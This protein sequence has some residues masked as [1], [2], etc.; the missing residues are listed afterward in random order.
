M[1]RKYSSN[2]VKN[3]FRYILKRGDYIKIP[4]EI[5][6]Q[7]YLIS[8][9]LLEILKIDITIYERSDSV[10]HKMMF[11][12]ISNASNPNFNEDGRRGNNIE[13]YLFSAAEDIVSL[14]LDNSIDESLLRRLKTNNDREVRGALYEVSIAAAFLRNG[15]KIIWLRGQREPEFTAVLGEIMIDVEAKRR[16]RHNSIHK[17]Y[18]IEKELKAFR[19]NLSKALRKKRT[20]KYL[21]CLDSDL[22]PRSSIDNKDLYDEFSKQFGNY[23]IDNT[24]VL[25]TNSGYEYLPDDNNK[26]NSAY[27]LKDVNSIDN[28]IIK[29]LIDS[30]NSDLPDAVSKNWLVE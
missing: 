20:H 3:D 7:Q 19:Q 24:T 18:N 9:L 2:K 4:K 13:T 10:F 17:A 11:E 29:S 1:L 15:Y 8:M 28:K 12:Y 26:R 6:Y 25:M 27:V 23:N 21:I 30:L 22:P 5:H 16:D 14:Y